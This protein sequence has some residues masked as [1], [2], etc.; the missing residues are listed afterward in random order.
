MVGAQYRQIIL[1]L[2]PSR[3]FGCIGFAVGQIKS[4]LIYPVRTQ[5]LL[6]GVIIRQVDWG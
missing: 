1:R 5:E 4:F 3:G 6:P 2:F